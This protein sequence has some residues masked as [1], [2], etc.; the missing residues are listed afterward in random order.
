MELQLPLT[1]PQIWISCMSKVY[2]IMFLQSAINFILLW[3][4]Y[5]YEYPF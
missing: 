2:N 3:F 4:L 5:K 1:P